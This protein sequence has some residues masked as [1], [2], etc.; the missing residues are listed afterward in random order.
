MNFLGFFIYKI[1]PM[2][3]AGMTGEERKLRRL[4]GQHLLSK[5]DSQTVV[6]NLCGVQAQL[7]GNA[8]HVL[9]I[10]CNAF[11]PDTLVKNR[12]LRGTVHVFS[13]EDLPLFI[14]PER[15]RLEDWSVPTWWNQR[16]DWAR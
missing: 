3:G 5:T 15:Y 10:R 12:T 1:K 7:M 9:A 16:E 13:M 8:R 4:A 11:H 14:P 2:E 6:K